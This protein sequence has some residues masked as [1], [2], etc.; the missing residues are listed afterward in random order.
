M[1]A[2]AS[3]PLIWKMNSSSSETLI[4][5]K[6][7]YAK[8]QILVT[9][10]SYSRRPSPPFC[11]QSPH[12]PPPAAIQMKSFTKHHPLP[13]QIRRHNHNPLLEKLGKR[14]KDLPASQILKDVEHWREDLFWAVIRFLIQH[15]RPEEVL[16]VF[17]LW[18]NTTEYSRTNE[19]NYGKII[20]MLSES[21]FVKEAAGALAEMKRLGVH[22]SL[23]IYNFVIHGFAMK[24][25][26]DDASFFF[27]EMGEANLSPNTETYHGLIQAYG[28]YEMYD[29]IGMCLKK[30]ESSNQSFPDHISYNLLIRE[31]ARGGLL[32]RM[33]RVYQTLLS[34]RLGLQSSTLVAMLEVYTS[35]GLLEKMEKVYRRILNS[36]MHLKEDLIRR[37]ARAYIKN[38]MFSRLD[39]L[40]LD[41]FV[42][43][44]KTDLVWCLR[45]LCHACLSSRKGM[46][47]IIW[48]ME[49]AKVPWNISIANTILL[50]YLK[51]KDFKHLRI[52]IS[53]LPIRGV[54]PDIVT[55]G[56]IY[57]ASMIGFDGTASLNAWRRMGFLDEVVEM[58]TDPLVL[59]AF[60]KGH[61]LVSCEE[62]Y[63]SLEAEARKRIWTY[64]MLINLV[65]KLI[66]KQPSV[67]GQNL[68]FR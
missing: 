53:D 9:S 17:D 10:L 24:G 3:E 49:A 18:T 36:R 61:F 13:L 57:D 52:L 64:Q 62:M 42:T 40:G 55:V 7:P 43:N 25:K 33:E 30:M 2:A 38:Y 54:K 59:S 65:F 58:N 47:S 8:T 22:P 39:Y 11:F 41:L 45:L 50:A 60:G 46:D 66:E 68:K 35:F 20:G 23:E 48:Q 6:P 34:K 29:E 19:Y 1:R 31:F 26:F 4:T 37:L 44:G 14:V 63:C 12:S 27:N 5:K 32:K 21:G 67:R 16:Q 28:M 51:I 15:S 56:I